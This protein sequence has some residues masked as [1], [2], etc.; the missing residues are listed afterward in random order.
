MPFDL[1]ITSEIRSH[2]DDL[3]DTQASETEG[4]RMIGKHARAK[5][6]VGVAMVGL[7]AE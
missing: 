1:R 4:D 6:R 2:R 5:Q 7:A 3:L